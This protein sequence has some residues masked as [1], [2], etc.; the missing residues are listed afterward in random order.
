MAIAFEFYKTLRATLRNAMKLSIVMPIYNEVRTVDAMIQKVERVAMPCEKEIIIVDDGSV[1]G[2]REILARYEHAHVVAY[3]EHNAGKGAAIRTGFARATGDYILIQDADLEY[4][5]EN[6]AALLEPVLLFNADVVFGSRFISSKAHRVLYFWHAVGNRIVTLL[7]NMTTNLNITDMETCYKLFRRDL[8]RH[9]TLE[10][11]RF[12]IEPELTA[13]LA[14]IPGI[15]IFETGISY[16]GRTYEDGKKITWKDGV[17]ALW[18][19]LK[20]G[21]LK[22]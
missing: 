22:K 6:Y 15:K 20:Y 5:P 18:C 9:F 3:H 1:D 11:N 12:G 2:T 16:N 8:L 10:E 4:D 7:S 19:I 13:K 21:I 14:R 17:R